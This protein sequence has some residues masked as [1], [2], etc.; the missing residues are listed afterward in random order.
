MFAAAERRRERGRFGPRLVVAAPAVVAGEVLHRGEVPVAAGREQLLL[1]RGPGR[2]G[3][4]G[5]PGGA[6]PDR[7]REERRRRLGGRSRARRRRR[8]SPGCA[9]ASARPRS[10]GSCCTA[11]PSRGRCCSPGCRCRPTGSSRSCS[12]PDVRCRHVVCSGSLLPPALL[13]SPLA[14]GFVSRSLPITIWSIWPTFSS[15]VMRWSR[16][17]TRAGIDA[18]GFRYTGCPAPGAVGRGECRDDERGEQHDD[19][20]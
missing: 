13:Q 15:S 14:G 7:L 19:G 8:R 16:S 11:R 6:H 10:A 12:R 2:L 17:L 20:R 18:C 9:G 1:R 4:V 3:E 5:V